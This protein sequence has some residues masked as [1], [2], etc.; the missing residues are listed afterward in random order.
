MVEDPEAGMAGIKESEPLVQDRTSFY[1][2]QLSSTCLYRGVIIPSTV[3]IRCNP[4]TPQCPNLSVCWSFG[5]NSCKANQAKS[6][7]MIQDDKLFRLCAITKN[8]SGVGQ[9]ALQWHEIQC[10]ETIEFEW[11]LD[12]KQQK[13]IHL[14][15]THR[16][17]CSDGRHCTRLDNCKVIQH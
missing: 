5:R 14:A 11:N 1:W 15:T 7:I 2:H 16:N 9:G 6:K 17:C 3:L 12:S 8:K 13:A 4:Q 10:N